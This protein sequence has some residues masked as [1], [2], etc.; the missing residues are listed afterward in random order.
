[1]ALLEAIPRT[2]VEQGQELKVIEGD[3]PSAVHPPKGCRFHTRCKYCMER[4]RQFEPEFKEVEDGHFVACFLTDATEEEIQRALEE[5][6]KKSEAEKLELK[7]E[8]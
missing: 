1:K 4:C 2:D 6:A 8:L 7:T 5:N 3:I